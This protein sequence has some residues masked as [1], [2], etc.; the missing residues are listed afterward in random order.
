MIAWAIA[1]YA[2][3]CVA[4]TFVAAH[5]SW[6]HNRRAMPSNYDGRDYDHRDA[7]HGD[8]YV[9]TIAAPMWPGVLLMLALVILPIAWALDRLGKRRERRWNAEHDRTNPGGVDRA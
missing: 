7:P 8:D 3:S 1:G 6:R 4:F 5:V 9:W 2:A